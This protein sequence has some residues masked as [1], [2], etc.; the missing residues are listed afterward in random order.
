MDGTAPPPLSTDAFLNDL[1]S[2]IMDSPSPFH[3]VAS[4]LDRLRSAGFSVINERLPWPTEPGRYAVVR[5]GSLLAYST[6]NS[7]PAN[8]YRMIGA[9]T[10]SPNLRIRPRPDRVSAGFAQ[11]AVEVYGGAL[12]NSWL[13]RDLGLSGRVA[14][15]TGTGSFETVLVAFDEPLLRIPQLAIH[16]DQ[17]LATNGLHLNPQLHLT[18]VWGLDPSLDLRT[19]LAQRLAVSPKNILSWELMCHDITTPSLL[20]ADG[21]MFAAP[22]L[23]NQLSCHASVDALINAVDAAGDETAVPMICLFDHEEVGSESASGAAGSLLEVVLE[24]ISIGAGLSRE[25]HLA[26]LASSICISADGAHAT[27]PNYVD[28]HEPNHHIALGAGPVLKHNESRRYASDAPGLALV[29]DVAQQAGI[30]LQ[31]FSSRGDMRCGSTIGPITAARLGV[32]TI[33]LGVAQLS[34][35]S[36][37]ELCGAADP[38]RFATLLTELLRLGTHPAQQ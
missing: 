17:T 36:A 15:S 2:F 8:G 25:E 4:S 24:R 33:D 1:R 34:M 16:L 11:L 3:A 14:V 22:R 23:D 21:S 27:H 19:F 10:D 29:I 28:C 32:R 26:A 5:D 9:H 31:H 35:H 37:R 6:E 7:S 13:D 18:P 30:A 12:L 38:L 20:G